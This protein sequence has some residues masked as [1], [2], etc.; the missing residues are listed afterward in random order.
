MRKLLISVLL[1]SLAFTAFADDA[2]VLP[3]GVLRATFANILIN[4]DS[5]YDK[6]GEKQDSN[7]L[8]FDN[9]GSALEFGVTDIITAAIQWAPGT[10]VYTDFES[11]TLDAVFTA[12]SIPNSSKDAVFTG[13][14]DL[15]A[16]AKIQVV[17]TSD[18][19]FAFAPGAKIPLDSY[20]AAVEGQAMV[21]GDS[22]R[23]FSQSSTESLGLG[24]RIY[25]DWQ[26]TE[27]LFINLYNQTIF[28]LA[29]DKYT[30]DDAVTYAAN[31]NGAYAAAIGGG[32]TPTVAA[33]IA[34][35][36][37]TDAISKSSFEYPIYLDFEIE[38]H[39]DLNL[40]K[41]ANLSFSVPVKYSMNGKVTVEGTE[42]DNSDAFLL[43]VNPGMSF[44]YMGGFPF[45]LT[46]NYDYPL[47]GKNST[48]KSVFTFKLKLFYDFY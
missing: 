28:Y 14:S 21:D 48:T 39:Y 41:T 35:N 16:G 30:K 2:K 24:G 40:N 5:E 20:D 43:S 17:N 7:K 15:F 47:A 25:F 37:A 45:E 36:T 19:R 13:L 34:E 26:I 18:M 29:N 33:G 6:D 23:V 4:S 44:F 10:M 31:Y 8:L 46:A 32:A 1:A 11:A 38:P 9:F 12:Y 3:S 22:Y 27:D 42:K